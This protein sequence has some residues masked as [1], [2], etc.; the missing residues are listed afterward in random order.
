MR[1]AELAAWLVIVAILVWLAVME[2]AAIGRIGEQTPI[3]ET[4]WDR[5]TVCTQ[6]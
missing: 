5:E 4:N 6:C 2:L 1:R 3:Q